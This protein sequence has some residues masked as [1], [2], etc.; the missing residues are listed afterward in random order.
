QVENHGPDTATNCYFAAHAICPKAVELPF[1]ESFR[2]GETERDVRAGCA[3]DR[4]DLHVV[5]F[6]IHAGLDKHPVQ[7]QVHAGSGA[8][9]E[10]FNDAQITALRIQITAND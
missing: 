1:F 6:R 2:R 7:A 10:T 5:L 9:A 3:G 4:H 8:D